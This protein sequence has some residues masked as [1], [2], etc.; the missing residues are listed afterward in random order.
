MHFHEPEP[1]ARMMIHPTFTPMMRTTLLFIIAAL[2]AS[3]DNGREQRPAIDLDGPVTQEQID[4]IVST[5]SFVYEDPILQDSSNHVLI[6]MKIDRRSSNYRYSSTGYEGD[7]TSGYWNLLF[8]DLNGYGTHLLTETKMR[9]NSIHVHDSTSGK[10][11]ARRIL[12]SIIDEDKNKDGE[13][14]GLDPAHLSISNQDG[15]DLK[16]ISPLEEDLIGWD[17]L[18]GRDQIAF[19]H[20]QGHGR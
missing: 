2:I 7:Y 10:L 3:C 20:A 11:I 13:L 16:A 17:L 6:P 1:K 15:S 5:F 19:T 9:I 4:S 14:T 18:E 8:M 12:Y